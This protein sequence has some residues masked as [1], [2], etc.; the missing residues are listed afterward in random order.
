MPGHV[1]RKLITPKIVTVLRWLL[2]ILAGLSLFAW[3]F[4]CWLEVCVGVRDDDYVGVWRGCLS[5]SYDYGAKWAD[6]TGE[7]SAWI[8]RRNLPL[9][10]WGSLEWSYPHPSSMIFIRL[11]PLWA[12]AL[13]CGLPAAWLWAKRRRLLPT[14]CQKCGY[15]LSATPA[16]SKCP[17][18]GAAIQR[19][20]RA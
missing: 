17:E 2:T 6:H 9:L 7:P 3:V 11:I 19:S 8:G 5:I 18:C 14:D 1:M 20:P 4:S 12:I 10:H 15:D 13:V 16:I